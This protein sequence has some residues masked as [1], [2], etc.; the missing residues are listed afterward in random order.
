MTLVQNR[1]RLLSGN[2][3]IAI[4]LWILFCSCH[5]IKSSP[6]EPISENKPKEEQ[7]VKKEEPKAKEPK[8]QVSGEDA[9]EEI[10]FHGQS[11]LVPAKKTSFKVAVILP[12]HLGFKTKSQKRIADIM[13]DYYQGMRLAL[14]E[15][16]AQ[17][18]VVDVTV[19][20][21]KND[22][23][24]LKRI[25][26]KREIYRM[27]LVIGP[28]QESQIKIASRVL[29]PYKIPVFS[30]FTALDG[31]SDT[32]PLCY[33]FVGGNELKANQFADYL[34]RNHKGKKLV[35]LR[36]GR[37]YDKD[38]VPHL[39]K[40][41]DKKGKIKYV[42]EAYKPTIAWSNLLVKDKETLVFIASK[43][44]NTVQNCLGGLIAAKRDV[45]VFGDHS[46]TNFNDNDY[47]FW[48]NLNM[49]VLATEFENTQDSSIADLRL[50]FRET[51]AHDPSKYALR[52]YDQT[53][54]IGDALM[55]FGEHF[56]KF[57]NEHEFY[58]E[59]TYYNFVP[60]NGCRQNRNLKVLRYED[61][62]LT[63][64]E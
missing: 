44:Q 54:F 9:V 29:K 60:M 46:W 45:I 50:R 43:Q 16:E 20:D 51:F 25:L 14:D 18:L 6:V 49:H 40:A 13:M 7:T 12:F 19:Y 11:F 47:M 27:D 24:E 3:H 41:L 8:K 64:T 28:I 22:S 38:F 15:L 5:I 31:L 37:S 42:K 26:R 56:P 63:I 39:T 30:P 57:V 17:G 1:L 4:A 59:H 48:E 32:N 2:K 35:I 62:Q 10:D 52:G 55:A 21:N 23:N 36:D 58:Y 53:T 33:T 34:E 61:H